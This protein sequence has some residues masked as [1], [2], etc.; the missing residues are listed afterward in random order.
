MGGMC[1]SGDYGSHTSKNASPLISIS[2]AA[3]ASAAAV[4][5]LL[6]NCVEKCRSSSTCAAATWDY[7]NDS[8][9]LWHPGTAAPSTYTATGGIALKTV[10]SMS[11]AASFKAPAAASAATAATI[12]AGGA[13]AAA[14]NQVQAKAM[15]SG[16]YS[17]TAGSAAAAWVDPGSLIKVAVTSLNECLQA[18]TFNLCSGVVFGALDAA[19]GRIGDIIGAAAGTKCQRIQGTSLPG[20]SHR[21]L[22][23]ANHKLLEPV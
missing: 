18:C 12:A 10:N 5:S 4:C 16:Y 19:T 7:S 15:G 3:A 11:V 13:A 22:I 8:C 14:S 17:Y 21:T 23:K 2:A 1:L 9:K 20:N 6:Q